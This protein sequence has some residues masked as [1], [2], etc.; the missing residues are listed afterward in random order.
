M[1]LDN[2]IQGSRCYEN[3]KGHNNSECEHANDSTPFSNSPG[4]FLCE[5]ALQSTRFWKPLIREWIVR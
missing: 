4:Y 1:A 5:Q 3:I 2:W